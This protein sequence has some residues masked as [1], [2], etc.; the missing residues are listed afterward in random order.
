MSAPGIGRMLAAG[1]ATVRRRPGLVLATFLAYAGLS[2][3]VYLLLARGLAAHIARRPV[4]DPLLG[5]DLHVLW[6]CLRGAD[7]TLAAAATA[8]LAAIGA[9]ALL[10]W[11][12]VAGVI[13]VFAARPSG[14]RASGE[15]FASA[16]VTRLWPFARLWLWSLPLWAV[17]GIAAAIG[18]GVAPAPPVD[19]ETLAALLGPRL[20]ALLPAALL[21]LWLTTVVRF[22]RIDLVRHAPLSPLRALVRALLAVTTR[23]RVLLH[24][25][26]SPLLFAVVT[27][28]HVAL[29]AGQLGASP[30]ALLALAQLAALLRHLGT[31]WIL[32]GQVELAEQAL[33]PPLAR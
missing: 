12:L 3:L 5:G 11:A 26:L 21:A 4:C 27:A 6:S 14:A 20:L 32:A 8:A 7:G 18:L 23:P 9:Y 10:S 17:V 15:R 25:A 19:A 31:L 2:A 29:T 24:A 22:A 13:A 30:L 28:G 33:F 16:A 1:A